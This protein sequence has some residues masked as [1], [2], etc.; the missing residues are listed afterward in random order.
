MVN[1]P[2]APAFRSFRLGLT[3]LVVCRTKYATCSPRYAVRV[4]EARIPD[5]EPA[6]HS[7]FVERCDPSLRSEQPAGDEWLHA[8][9]YDGYCAQLNTSRP[10]EDYILAKKIDEEARLTKSIGRDR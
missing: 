3:L 10:R 4:Q 8:I 5:A 2:F 9:K 6:P 1:Q 7:G